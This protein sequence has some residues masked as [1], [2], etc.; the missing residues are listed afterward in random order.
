MTYTLQGTAGEIA[1][2]TACA[3]PVAF[4]KQGFQAQHWDYAGLEILPSAPTVNEGGTL[5]LQP[6][7]VLDD[8]SRLNLAGSAATWAVVAGTG[9]V[10]SNALFTA[11]NVYQ[12]GIATVQAQFTPPGR[13]PFTAQ[14]DLGVLDT[15]KDNFGIYAGDGIDDAWQVQYFGVNNP[16]GLA[17]AD[18]DGDGQTNLFEFLGLT[19]PNGATSPFTVRL[20]PVS[21]QPGTKRITWGPVNPACNYR[22]EAKSDLGA[23]TWTALTAEL[24]GAGTGTNSYDDT[25]ATGA[26]KFYRVVITK[27]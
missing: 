21:G 19:V 22:V 13:T 4:L 24:P 16:A 26:R 27:P 3:S 18:P 9:T 7:A 5:Q 8:A 6:R 20:D 17:A 12:D 25:T 2:R 10:S 14:L 1:G 15:I 23:A 11:G